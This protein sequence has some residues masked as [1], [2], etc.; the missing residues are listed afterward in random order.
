MK[1]FFETEKTVKKI[2]KDLPITR[3]NDNLLYIRYWQKVAPNVSFIDFFREPNKYDGATYKRVERCRR[4][5]Q[6]KFPEL[7]SVKV[8]EFRFEQEIEFKQ[9]GL[10]CYE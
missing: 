2:L 6:E 7:K 1:K 3:G 8:A 9:Y 4:K 5:L 10:G